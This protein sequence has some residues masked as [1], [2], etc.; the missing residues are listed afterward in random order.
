LLDPKSGFNLK[1]TGHRIY[2]RNYAQPSTYVAAGAE[3]VNSYVAEGCS[4]RGRVINSI[5]STACVIEEG[6]LVKDSV[7]MPNAAIGRGSELRYAI[8]GENAK[9]GR[10]VRVG[11]ER[12]YYPAEAFGIAVVGKNKMIADGSVIKPKEIV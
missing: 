10:G 4:V 1:E 8:L 9:V 7:V 5:V 6:A 2:A 11:G 3:V 12:E